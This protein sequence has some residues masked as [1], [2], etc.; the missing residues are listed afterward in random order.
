MIGFVESILEDLDLFLEVRLVFG[1]GVHTCA[2]FLFLNDFLLEVS[3]VN[4]DIVLNLFFLLD[5]CGDFCKELFHI[6]HGLMVL[7][8]GFLIVDFGLRD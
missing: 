4:V 2:V 3:D 1:A 6:F 5:D 8:G 7:I